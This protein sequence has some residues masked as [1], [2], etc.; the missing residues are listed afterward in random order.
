MHNPG[1]LHIETIDADWC[2]KDMVLLHAC[3]QLLTDFIEKEKADELTDWTMDD[4]TARAKLEIDELYTWWKDRKKREWSDEEYER[5][6]EMLIR[7][8]KI[9]KHLWT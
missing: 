9:R 4:K 1:N 2:D 7:L 5:D 3:F 8:I 6:N